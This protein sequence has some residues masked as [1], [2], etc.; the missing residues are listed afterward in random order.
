MI[1]KK[2]Y[3]NKLL[4]MVLLSIPI[5]GATQKY[6]ISGHVK[7]G[8]NGEHLIDAT[9]LVSELSGVG[10]ITNTSVIYSDYNYKIKID[11]KALELSSSIGDVNFK[12][13]F[14]YFLNNNNH[15]K[16]GAN[17]IYHTFKPGEAISN[18]DGYNRH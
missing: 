18:S 8:S 15:L 10:T 14:D 13:D 17:I 11:D 6:T 12:Q 1:L 3:L 9:I 7:D 4:L 2:I 5:L 16:F